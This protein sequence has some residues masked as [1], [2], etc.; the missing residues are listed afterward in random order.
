MANNSDKNMAKGIVTRTGLTLAFLDDD[1][2]AVFLKTPGSNSIIFDDADEMIQIAD[3]H[4]NTITM[5]KDGI[6]LK[7]AKDFKIEA[8]GNVE[9]KGAKVDVK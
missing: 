9:I 6:V 7:S 4:G 2:P 8:S 5:S 1:K 3:K